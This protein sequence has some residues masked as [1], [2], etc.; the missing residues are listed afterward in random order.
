M[1]PQFAR[2]GAK[3]PSAAELGA[4]TR[5]GYFCPD[6]ACAFELFGVLPFCLFAS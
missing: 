4:V 5:I 3:S 2:A 6:G 1:V